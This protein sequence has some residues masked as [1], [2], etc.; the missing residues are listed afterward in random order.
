MHIKKYYDKEA[1]QILNVSDLKNIADIEEKYQ[2]LFRMNDKANGGS[3][4]L[5]SKVNEK[6]IIKLFS[7]FI[8]LYVQQAISYHSCLTFFFKIYRAKERIDEELK[9]EKRTA[10]KSKET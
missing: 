3:F 7:L 10:A 1:K 4:Y 6:Y 9:N 8:N 2:N 5:Q